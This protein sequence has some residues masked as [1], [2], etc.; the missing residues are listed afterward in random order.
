MIQ[1]G[2][3]IDRLSVRPCALA[4]QRSSVASFWEKLLDICHF[5]QRC[6]ANISVNKL[7]RSVDKIIQATNL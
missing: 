4:L 5:D 7:Q 1:T 2:H 6:I 3:E